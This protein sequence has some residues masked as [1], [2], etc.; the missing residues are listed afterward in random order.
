[1]QELEHARHVISELE[2]NLKAERAQLRTMTNTQSRMGRE[3]E[4][5]AT[6]LQRTEVVSRK[7]H[8]FKEVSENWQRQDMDE[9]KQNLRKLKQD[10]LAL[11]K[12]LRSRLAFLS[13]LPSY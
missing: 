3:K 1:M 13:Y 11:E 7:I 8:I 12:E 10:N 4:D 5:I 6:Q 9:V 2:E